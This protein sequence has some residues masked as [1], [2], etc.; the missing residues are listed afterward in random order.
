MHFQRDRTPQRHRLPTSS[1][2][3]RMAMSAAPLIRRQLQVVARMRIRQSFTLIEVL[4]VI[5]IIGL[6]VGLLLGDG[7]TMFDPA[8][9][10][11]DRRLMFAT[12]DMGR[13]YRSTDGGL[14]WKMLDK[15]GFGFPAKLRCNLTRPMPTRC[16][17]WWRPTRGHTPDLLAFKLDSSD[18]PS[19]SAKQ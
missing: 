1:S 16:M 4:V 14:S 7:G 10:P 8:C 13:V 6:L 11:H 17:P 18:S 9:S 19:S 5:A 2:K 12:R 3:W 15:P